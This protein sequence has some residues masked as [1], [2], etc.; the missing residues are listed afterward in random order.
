MTARAFRW[1]V[2]RIINVFITV[3]VT[4][5]GGDGCCLSLSGDFQHKHGGGVGLTS[6]LKD[7]KCHK[8]TAI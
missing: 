7:V 2:R 1:K 3:G 5:G 4:N 6:D 8:V